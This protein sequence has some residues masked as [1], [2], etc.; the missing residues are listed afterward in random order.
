MSEL[1]IRNIRSH[2]IQVIEKLEVNQRLK[3]DKAGRLKVAEGFSKL[4]GSI[5]KNIP[6]EAEQATVDLAKIKFEKIEFGTDEYIN[7]QKRLSTLHIVSQ[8]KQEE[9]A[10]IWYDR[11]FQNL[12]ES[13]VEA[14]V[15]EAIVTAEICEDHSISEASKAPLLP[16]ATQ[17][18]TS[19]SYFLKNRGGKKIGV[20]KPQDEEIFM[21]N[22]P[23]GRNAQYFEERLGPRSGHIQG[24]SFLKEIAAYS[25]AKDLFDHVPLTTKIEIPFRKMPESAS[26]IRKM[27]SFQA[28][29]EGEPIEGLITEQIRDMPIK[30]VQK[31][32]L[33][34]LMVGNSD[35]NMG[36]ALY[37]SSEEVLTPIDH[38]LVFLDSL[39][40]MGGYP[41]SELSCQWV[42]W[43]QVRQPLEEELATSFSDYNLNLE[44]KCQDLGEL[45]ISEGSIRE[46]KI[47]II[48]L[49]EALAKDLTLAKIAQLCTQTEEESA[50]PTFLEAIVREIMYSLLEEDQVSNEEEFFKRFTEITKQKLQ[51]L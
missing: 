35:R 41:V 37:D 36:N 51:G 42:V 28:F 14:R 20:F 11:R 49:K 15:A 8:G 2:N 45:E 50:R 40:W 46:H 1:N 10:F 17:G 47:R 24:T 43:P 23:R 30:E 33:F 22:N 7:F 12:V 5:I 34:D 26:V 18:G 16:E 44:K 21:P 6:Q 4:V 39:D 31:M 38:G 27:G 13:G 19:G 9:I 29:A 3:V 48:F 25:I 32:A